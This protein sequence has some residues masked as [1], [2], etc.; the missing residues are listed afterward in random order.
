MNNN[1]N[2]NTNFIDFLHELYSNE[3]ET[4]VS[5]TLARLQQHLDQ[6]RKLI[7][8]EIATIK[9]EE[10]QLKTLVQSASNQNNYNNSDKNSSFTLSD[11][12]KINKL[13]LDL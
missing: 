7:L 12:E 8:N 3:S 13:P 6:Q 9:E 1:N 2:N 11:I 10:Q 4:D 5:A